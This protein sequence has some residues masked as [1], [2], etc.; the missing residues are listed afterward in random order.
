M[1][2]IQVLMKDGRKFE[3]QIWEWRPTEG[4]F[5][6]CDYSVAN[7]P[8]RIELKDVAF[9]KTPGQ[10]VSIDSPPE[11]EEQDELARARRNGWIEKV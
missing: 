11:G 8:T 9:A 5:T 1:H 2:D 10:R 3:G 6:I 7:E 4:Y